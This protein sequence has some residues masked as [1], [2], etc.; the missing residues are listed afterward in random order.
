MIVVTDVILYTFS[1]NYKLHV[2]VVIP[3]KLTHTGTMQL[4]QQS[5][6]VVGSLWPF[7]KV[8]Y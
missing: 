7:T 5:L 4:Q 3:A 2:S 1:N 6:W 8:V